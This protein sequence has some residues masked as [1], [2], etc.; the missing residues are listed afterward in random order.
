MHFFVKT[1]LGMILSSDNHLCATLILDTVSDSVMG[2]Q[3]TSVGAPV[4]F[5]PEPREH[6]TQMKKYTVA[7]KNYLQTQA[8]QHLQ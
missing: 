4:T 7:L 8:S 6:E 2:S 3:T 5:Q 1:D